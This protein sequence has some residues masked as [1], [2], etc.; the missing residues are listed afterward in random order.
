MAKREKCI[1]FVMMATLS[2]S[3][4]SQKIDKIDR[5]KQRSEI[6]KKGKTSKS[7]TTGTTTQKSK[8]V[9]RTSPNSK[10]KQA[11]YK[12][13][14]EQT[15]TLQNR[16]ESQLQ[17]QTKASTGLRV[18]KT[19]LIFGPDGGTESITV[20]SDQPWS[21]Y[22]QPAGWGYLRREGNT[23]TLRVDA[24]TSNTDRADNFC[25]KSIDN[26]IRINVYQNGKEYIRPY[27]SVS[28]SDL[29]F[30]SSGGSETISVSSNV[31]WEIQNGHILWAHLTKTGNNIRVSIEENL[32]SSRRIDYFVIKAGDLEK[33]INLTQSGR[34]TS[35]TYV[36]SYDNTI[37]RSKDYVKNWWWKGRVRVGWNVTALD[38]DADFED[39]SWRSGLRLRF[40]KSTD[41]FNLILGCDYSMQRRYVEGG[42]RYVHTGERW[43][44]YNYNYGHYEETGYW[45]YTSSEFKLVH[46]EIVIPIELRFNFAK[47]GSAGRWYLGTGFDFGFKIANGN[48]PSNSKSYILDPQFGIMWKH[49]DLGIDYR[50]YQKNSQYDFKNARFGLYGTWY[51]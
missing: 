9:S 50:I 25:L 39:M 4:Y 12:K 42:S 49:F 29:N 15:A 43:V 3:V 16:I 6:I 19:E 30:Y 1:I 51:F 36:S 21:I 46:H 5:T 44:Q 40:G 34:N 11:T 10:Q 13:S 27:L 35:S 24:N 37:I 2:L 48:L 38:I 22:V 18:S 8:S 17:S 41:W 45:D 14:T 31:D 47:C 33:R 28:K 26:E 20:I 7:A 23:L 32:S